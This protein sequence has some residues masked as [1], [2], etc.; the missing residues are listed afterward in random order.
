[1]RGRGVARVHARFGHVELRLVR[2]VA[3]HARLR[4]GAEQGALRTLQYLDAL[5]IRGV[6]VEIA[7][8][9][10]RGLLIEVDGDVRETTV[11]S[12]RLYS[13]NRRSRGRAYRCCSDSGPPRAR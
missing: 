4:A 7:A 13:R 2:D 6:D 10:L 12:R 11:R 5:E 8:R 9:K 1:M 3:Q